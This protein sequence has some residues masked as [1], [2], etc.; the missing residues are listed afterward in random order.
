[1]SAAGAGNYPRKIT[2]GEAMVAFFK[3]AGIENCELMTKPHVHRGIDLDK[4]D[5]FKPR[6]KSRKEKAK[7]E[8]AKK[9]VIID[10]AT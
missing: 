6:E 4:V 8:K 3:E 1:V 10:N 9:V 2:Q 5:P 7:K